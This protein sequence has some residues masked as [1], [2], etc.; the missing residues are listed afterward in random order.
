MQILHFNRYSYLEVSYL[1]QEQKPAPH[2]NS[3]QHY[4]GKEHL[5]TLDPKF[6][7]TEL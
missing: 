2:Q 6:P 4:T 1:E 7:L 3:V 5:Q